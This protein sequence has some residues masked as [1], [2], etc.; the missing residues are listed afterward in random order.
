A[1]LHADGR[2]GSGTRPAS[3]AGLT[4]VLPL[5]L[6]GLLGAL[7]DLVERQLD[8]NLQVEPACLGTA[9]AAAAETAQPAEDVVE[10]R[11]DV[12]DVHVREVVRALHAGVAE[13][14]VAA[15]LL[16]VG[17]HLVGFGTF[18]EADRKSVV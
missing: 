16:L 12:A 8:L 15:A 10:H 2:A 18:L 11:E 5:E 4:Q 14:V 9:A 6:D 1:A 3:V 13:L 17:E 7:G